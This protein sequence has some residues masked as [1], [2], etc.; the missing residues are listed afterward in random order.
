M[1][2]FDRF[3]MLEGERPEAPT[4]EPT[5]HIS[6]RFGAVQAPAPAPAAPVA[7]DPFAPPPVATLAID[8]A[9]IRGDRRPLRCIA[10]GF[11]SGPYAE[12]CG[13]CGESLKSAAVRH[14]NLRLAQDAEAA[15][16]AARRAAPPPEPEP[17]PD[18]PARPVL[19]RVADQISPAR[20]WSLPMRRALVI[21][22]LACL[23]GTFWISTG[24]R[25]FGFLVALVVT[26][27]IFLLA[28]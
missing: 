11:E 6:D 10:C 13:K 24:Q 4:D 22:G 12:A 16:F 27:G 23:L 25:V 26:I 5:H 21:G 19:D 7:H 14:L 1:K 2:N 18:E 9:D 28:T 20:G 8:P 3:R 17:V 15:A